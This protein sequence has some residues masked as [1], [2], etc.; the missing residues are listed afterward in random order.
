MRKIKKGDTVVLLTGKCKGMQGIVLRV[1][2]DSKR[3]FVEG[4]NMVKK[5]MKANPQKNEPGGIIEKEASVHISNVAIY[6]PVTK[7]RDRIGFKMVDGKKRR[8]FKSND[9]LVDVIK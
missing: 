7:K 6:N 4:I 5:H 2:S 9:E 8:Y 3:C 1:V